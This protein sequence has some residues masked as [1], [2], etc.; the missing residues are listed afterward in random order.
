MCWVLHDNNIPTSCVVDTL[1]PKKE[2]I[3]QH[4]LSR[5]A[6]GHG[7][8]RSCSKVLSTAMSLA[9]LSSHS[10]IITILADAGDIM[11]SGAMEGKASL[12]L[13][14]REGKHF[15]IKLFVESATGWFCCIIFLQSDN[16]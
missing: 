8:F 5:T 14:F 1:L 4:L 12:P 3:Q 16:F 10:R 13:V 7:G 2:F 11:G 6:V 9:V 15:F